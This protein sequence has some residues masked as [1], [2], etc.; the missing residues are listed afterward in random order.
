MRDSARRRSIKLSRSSPY[1]SPTLV[2]ALVVLALL[3]LVLDR[4]G[5]LGP[6][7]GQAESL[8]SP[9]LRTIRQVG[10]GVGGLGQGLGG[11]AQLQATITAQNEQIS[12]LRAHS[13]E[14]QALKVRVAH[15]EQQLRIEQEHP[16]E[17]LGADVSAHTP[18]A[19]RRVLLLAAGSD[20]G[21]R[22]GMAVI[23][24]EGGSP[25]ALIGVVEQAGPRSATVLLITDFSSAVSALVYHDL[26]VA[27]G[28]VQGQWQRGSRLQMEQVDRSAPIAPGDVVVTAG[29]TAQIDA[30]LPRAAIPRDV[31]IGSVEA[32]RAEGQTQVAELRPFVDPDRVTYAWVILSHGE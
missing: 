29:L 15:L 16:W 8:I 2:V 13:I 3:L 31:P 11:A 32:A 10:D 26:G 7:R 17:L 12:Q 18:D 5:A 14:N 9:A 6:L 21:V 27:S 1:R 30:S 4:S 24:R 22:P 23:A 25:P 28:I 20:Q 19:G